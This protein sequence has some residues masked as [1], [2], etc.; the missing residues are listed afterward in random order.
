MKGT[1]STVLCRDDSDYDAMV[2]IIAV[3]ASRKNVII[4]I[5][6]I[7]ST[8]CHVAVLSASQED[9][10]AFAE[11]VKRVYSMWFNRRYGENGVLRRVSMSALYLDNDW[12][13]RN[14]L[15]YIPRNALDNGCNVNE[16]EWS[17]YRAMFHSPPAPAGVR[18]SSLNKR[19]RERILH[20]A[21]DLKGVRWRIDQDG[22][23]IPDSFCDTAYLEQAFNG[24]QAFF[25]KTIGNLNPLEM[26]E[27]LVDSPRMRVSDAELLKSI[28]EL[29]HRWFSA[30][31]T[32]IPLEKKMRLLPYVVRT[33]KTS[34]AQLSRIFGFKREV[35]EEAMRTLM[36]K[37]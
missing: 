26:N 12:Y 16:Y 7:V 32:D 31:L 23:L 6:A 36:K 19:D 5:Y 17:G 14:A 18:V 20:T 3:A 21:K 28:E 27:R 30:G 33:R 35:T 25:L 1:E 10:D 15:A 8:H 11:E 2:K 37:Q 29:S 22:H 4:I 34:A 9:A 13:V 24:D